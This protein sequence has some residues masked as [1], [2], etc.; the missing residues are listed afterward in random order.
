METKR[1]SFFDPP[2]ELCSQSLERTR[3]GVPVGE[4]GSQGF[5]CLFIGDPTGE[6]V[7]R[8]PNDASPEVGRETD[9][10]NPAMV[11]SAGSEPKDRSKVN[12]VL[13]SGLST[14]HGSEDDGDVVGAV[15]TALAEVVAVALQGDK[16]GTP[17]ELGNGG[18]T[19]SAVEPSP[20]TQEIRASSLGPSPSQIRKQCGPTMESPVEDTDPFSQSNG[21]S[22]KLQAHAPI[23]QQV[24]PEIDKCGQVVPLDEGVFCDPSHPPTQLNPLTNFNWVFL[25]G[26]WTLA[27][28]KFTSDITAR[29]NHEGCLDKHDNLEIWSSDN[30]DDE[31]VKETGDQ[32]V[33]TLGNEEDSSESL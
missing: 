15:T 28:N 11:L 2:G 8:G 33:A 27:P 22:N 3:E 13:S 30:Q 31:L 16:A 9:S 32:G 24:G 29:S 6:R 26:I 4:L 18:K 23:T 20:I 14:L 5:S 25:H 10:L 1:G 7:S 21:P 17:G 12:D 19:G